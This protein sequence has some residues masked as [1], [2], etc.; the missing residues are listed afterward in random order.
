MKG[1]V[2]FNQRIK[3]AGALAL[4]LWASTSFANSGAEIGCAVIDMF[5]EAMVQFSGVLERDDIVQVISSAP[6]NDNIAAQTAKMLGIDGPLSVRVKIEGNGNTYSAN[7]P[8]N[9][10]I[11]GNRVEPVLGQNIQKLSSYTDFKN[12]FGAFP[13]VSCVTSN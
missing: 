12:S 4:S 1:N 8:F 11:V 6:Q 9:Y 10:K 2:L 13:N 7:Y 3:L 5:E